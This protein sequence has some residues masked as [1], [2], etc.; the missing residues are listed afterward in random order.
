MSQPTSYPATTP[1]DPVNEHR[2]ERTMA[3]IG[4]LMTWVVYAYVIVVEIILFLGF[5]LLLLGANPS[6]GFVEWVYRS[7]DRAMRPFRGIFEPIELGVTGNDVPSIFESSIVFAMVIYGLVA[8][9]LS[10]LIHWL[11]GVIRRIDRD[12]ERREHE[13][14]YQ[15]YYDAVARTAAEQGAAVTPVPPSGT[16]PPPPVPGTAADVPPP[17]APP[18]G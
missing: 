6:S 11:S 4:R 8:L 12:N 13:R 14:L 7:V 18:A 9:A 3:V 10:G 16:V 2:F 17:A 5:L 15:Q 1:D